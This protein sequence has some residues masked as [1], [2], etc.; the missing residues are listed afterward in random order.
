M[1]A[2][3]RVFDPDGI[4]NPGALLPREKE[5]VI[6][7]PPE[8]RPRVA[9]DRTSLLAEAAGDATLAE[10]E[11]AA[12]VAGATL[13]FV[14]DDHAETVKDFVAKG[15]HGAFDPWVDPAD[16]LLAGFEATLGSG[17]TLAVRPAPRRAV[18]PD[19]VPL[20][21]GADGRVGV[22]TRVWLRV[23]LRGA[24]R[25]TTAAVGFDKSPPLTEAEKSL[26]E[27][28]FEAAKTS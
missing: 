27:R 15:A 16:H 2:L 12:N 24:L 23:H 11:R 9:I 21:F 28:A 26:M 18:G 6:P 22:V 13:G 10:V 8:N 4:L 14:I 5:N 25:P 19:L 17:E 3:Q 7:A 20:V 1:R